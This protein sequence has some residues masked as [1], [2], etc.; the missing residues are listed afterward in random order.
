MGGYIICPVDKKELVVRKKKANT[1]WFVSCLCGYTKQG[2]TEEE[3]RQKV[4]EDESR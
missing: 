1:Y 3:L 2:F 4:R